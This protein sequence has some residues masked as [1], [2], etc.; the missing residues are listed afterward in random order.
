MTN[1]CSY[2]N[3]F[4]K[5]FRKDHCQKHYLFLRWKSDPDRWTCTIDECREPIL[6]KDLCSL[7]HS[8]KRQY[9]D[10]TV[11]PT[12]KPRGRKESPGFTKEKNGYILEKVDPTY[13]GKTTRARYVAQ[14]RLVME[15]NIG[16][17]LLPF[18]Q[19][20]VHHING[21]TLDNRIEN[22]QLRTGSHG[23][24]ILNQCLD[25]GSHNTAAITI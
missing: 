13:A 15:R 16:R 17:F 22:L 6:I 25:C 20:T 7:H 3:C 2:D 10:P 21:D 1:T 18:P 11:I 19:E 9:G 8:R 5:L 14:H 24:G 23:Q 4:N 12:A